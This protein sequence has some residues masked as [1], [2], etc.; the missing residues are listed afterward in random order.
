M[1][2]VLDTDAV[3]TKWMPAERQSLAERGDAASKAQDLPWRARMET[4]WQFSGE[5]I[6]RMEAERAAEQPV[7]V[8]APVV[9]TEADP[10]T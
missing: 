5:E 8:A 2:L 10:A 1:R 4:I 3:V 9:T 6:D 7:P